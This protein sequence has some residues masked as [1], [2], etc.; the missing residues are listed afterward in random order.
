MNDQSERLF[1]ESDF[2][3]FE[4]LK[5]ANEKMDNK[6]TEVDGRKWLFEP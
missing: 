3:P 5:I 4:F 2:N 1:F 6:L